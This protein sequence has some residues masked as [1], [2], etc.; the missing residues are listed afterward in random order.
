MFAGGGRVLGPDFVVVG[1]TDSAILYHTLSLSSSRAEGSKLSRTH[2]LGR[3]TSLRPV[4]L[5]WNTL[6]RTVV[7]I[8]ICRG[9]ENIHLAN[10]YVNIVG[11]YVKPDRTVYNKRRRY[12]A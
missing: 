7:S 11:E 4:R 2:S 3:S 8:L 10:G 9:L 5:W 12:D 1:Q 6:N